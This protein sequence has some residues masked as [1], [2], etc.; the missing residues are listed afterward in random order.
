MAVLLSY[1]AGRRRFATRVHERSERN[2]IRKERELAAL[3]GR[4]A[5]A[6]RRWLRDLSTW[7]RVFQTQLRPY[8]EQSNHP[9]RV[10]GPNGSEWFDDARR[11]EIRNLTYAMADEFGYFMSSRN[12]GHPT[13]R[14][15]DRILFSLWVRGVRKIDR[16]ALLEACDRE[17]THTRDRIDSERSSLDR[18]ATLL[19]EGVYRSGS[20]KGE[21]YTAQRRE[22]LE[23]QIAGT[24][25]RIEGRKRALRWALEMREINPLRMLSRTWI[26]KENA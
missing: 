12:Q 5:D 26:D 6:K 11:G 8:I 10:K 19:R 24:K 4:I 18:A 13:R 21:P 9:D 22:V 20:R 25:S 1:A 23:R 7:P 3:P 16:D 2:R 17:I 14:D 15:K